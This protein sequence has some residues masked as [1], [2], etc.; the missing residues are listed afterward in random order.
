[1]SAA[2]DLVIRNGTVVDGTGGAPQ[3]GDVAVTDG[4]IV[5]VGDIDGSGRQEIDADGHVVTPGFVD[6]HTHMDA[7][8]FWDTMGSSS[9]WHG[10]TT[11]VMGNCGFTLAPARSDNRALVIRNLERAEDISPAAMAQGIDWT[12]ETFGQYLDAIDVLPKSI[13]Y[14]AQIGHSALRTWTM[15]ERAFEEAATEAD[16][17]AMCAELRRSLEAGAIGFTTS[18]SP[19]HETSDNRPVASRLADWNE[20]V[21]LVQV[22]GDHGSGVFELTPEPAFHSTEEAVRQEFFDRLRMLAVQTGVPTT[23]GMRATSPTYQWQL[24]LIDATV[25]AGGTMFAQTH[26]RGVSAI[27]SFLTQLP[28]DN[29]PEWKAV[30]SLP[31]SELLTALRD[32]DIKTRLVAACK[33]ADY[34]RSIGAEARAPDYDM[35]IVLQRPI[36]PN[37][38]V[39]ELARERGCDP[40]EVM[41][42]LA[43][44]SNLTQMFLQPFHRYADEDLVALMKSPHSVMTFSDSGAHVS[45]I[46]DCSIQTHLLSHWVRDEEAFTLSEAVHMLTQV[47]SRAWGF[48]DRGVVAPGYAADLNVF[49]PARVGPRLPEVADDLPGGGRRLVQRADG[50]LATVVAGAVTFS[51]G[52]Y[53]G[54]VPGRLIRSA[55][56][57]A[58]A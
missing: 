44:G 36:P 56:Q 20:V 13:N 26:S 15:G 43:V 1:M 5:G 2:H 33:N 10:V 52:E 30:R 19:A 48:L 31:A 47:P 50:F 39:A 23:F 58:K 3:V 51:E 22:L 32:P 28:F 12:W 14:A 49:D 11:V 42:D 46:V 6:G 55:P 40:V 24:E 45:Q 16:L 53:T 38:T 21:R 9:C 41:I 18:R 57:T 29:L 35:I 25:A 4:Q 27:L 37:P 54:A 7:Q 34:G 17:D 8:I